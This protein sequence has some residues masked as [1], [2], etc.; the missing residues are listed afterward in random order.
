VHLHVDGLAI[1]DAFPDEYIMKQKKMDPFTVYHT[2]LYHCFKRTS[3]KGSDLIEY[4]HNLHL[5]YRVIH[6]GIDDI[7]VLLKVFVA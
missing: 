7:D 3:M 6:I 1:H 5:W 4:H 2:N